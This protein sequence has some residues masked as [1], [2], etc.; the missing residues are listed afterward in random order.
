M[1]LKNEILLVYPPYLSKYKN[2]PLGLAYLGSYLESNGYPVNII[3]MDPMEYKLSDL[4]FYIR[5]ERPRVV[6]ISFMTNQFGSAIEISKIIKKI[7]SNIKVV[8]GGNHASSLSEELAEYD[9]VD[10][11]VVGEGEITTLELIRSFDTK[12]NDFS[13]IKGLVY[14]NGNSIF[15]TPPRPL[16]ENLDTIPF[17]LWRDFPINKYDEMI[18]GTDEELPAFSI[19]ATRGCPSKCAFCSSHVVFTRR[20]RKRTAKNIFD[21]MVF[22]NK[23][24]GA[25]HFNFLDDTFTID[26]NLVKDFC[27]LIIESK[28]GFKWI[29]NAR[30]NTVTLN[31][32]KLMKSA[33]CLNINFGVESGDPG[34]RKNIHK[35]VTSEQ[36]EN[37]H[38]W[39]REVGMKV[40]SYFMVGNRGENWDS[41]NKTIE[42]AKKLKTD[43]P[44]CSIATPFPGT[45]MQ[46]EFEKNDWI[47]IKDW[48]KYYTTP[49]LIQNFIPVCVTDKLTQQ[50][51][52]DAY[53]YVNAEFAKI[54]LKTKYGKYYIFKLK[55][56]QKE[57]Y[58]R[59]SNQGIIEFSKLTIKM[60]KGF[61]QN[62]RN[63]WPV[64]FSK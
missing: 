1:V 47:K 21:E 16:I 24:Y 53:Y 55:F 15:R 46:E 56:Y 27:D 61:I 32:L 35:G 33:G 12:H 39:A 13:K 44:S 11:V 50:E 5:N 60:I 42:L 34:V 28:F 52:L 26:Q 59:L 19:M 51:I 63:L 7:D 62:V 36:I 48:N 25:K 43:H 6:G 49:H 54:K 4:E 41:I 9:S 31:L 22:L 64:Q 18:L 37:A 20:S 23:N 45:P 30:V 40:F 2:P 57:V 58:K 29:A 3:D 17:P 38:M 10:F 14:K 8:M